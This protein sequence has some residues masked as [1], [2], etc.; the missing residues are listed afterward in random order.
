MKKFLDTLV[1]RESALSP[2]DIEAFKSNDN[3]FGTAFVINMETK[4][5]RLVEACRTLQ[6]VGKTFT[7]F[8]AISGAK[9]LQQG[10]Q[11]DIDVG[12]FFSILRPGE[13]GCVLSHLSLI[14]LAAQHPNQNNFTIIFEDDVVTSATSVEDTLARVAAID[15]REG[16]D[17]VY[18]GK[19]L[20]CC[21]KMTRIEDNIWRGVAPSC[22][23]A[24]AIKNSF[25]RK[26]MN[27]IEECDYGA[28]N[29]EYFNR[30]IDSI[31]GD[32]TINAEANTLVIH[33]AIFMQ[34]VL[35]TSSD[36]RASFL[37]NYLECR[38]TTGDPPAPPQVAPGSSQSG[39]PDWVKMTL[40][41]I[42]GVVLLVL[43][44]KFITRHQKPALYVTIVLLFVYIVILTMYFTNKLWGPPGDGPA[45]GKKI[46][47]ESFVAPN[48]TSPVTSQHFEVDTTHLLTKEYKAFNPNAVVKDGQIVTAFRVS[49]G[50][51]S[52]PLIE[53]FDANLKLIKSK[54]VTIKSD[55]KVLDYKMPL[56]FE[57]MRIF[58]HN[59]EIGLIGVNLDRNDTGIASMV[60][61]RLDE[62]LETQNVTHLTYPPV[63]SKT[64]K[65]W[66]PITL[67]G[68][69]LG[70]VVSVD[71]LLIVTQTSEDGTC[72]K[73]VEA[74][75]NLKQAAVR[76]ST[77]TLRGD[78]IPS[79]YQQVMGITNP[80]NEHFMLVHTK[81][82]EA[83]FK[84]DGKLIQYQ[85][86]IAIVDP[87]KATVR[88]SKPF[89]VEE[90]NRPHIEYVSGF[91]FP[92]QGDLVITYGLKDEEA[93]F[94]PLGAKNMSI[95]F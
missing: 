35:T 33:P 45:A 52:Y 31:L 63:A 8:K 20:E 27:D 54:R 29:C 49:N 93:K 25:A 72:S 51:A 3:K 43:L 74:P 38:D 58:E 1:Q 66:A 79:E 83:D 37:H 22:C 7:R 87:Y 80:Q 90:P 10:K 56:G 5:E 59:G 77:V 4:P 62:N 30:G 50:K 17:L 40:L 18:L 69:R 16:V 65:N 68:N 48:L 42:V 19:C 85:H 81:Y 23:H 11:D 82:V 91:F 64:N 41:V 73:V 44:T 32:Y 39:G 28:P 71:P 60:V 88:L 70:Y 34:D 92:P 24:Y 89:H 14:N 55:R 12:Q 6:K 9:I 2:Q 57:D 36:L 84:K 75:Q 67:S 86:Y 15:D 53:V 76:N 95:L 61:A 94:F 26:V 46:T 47:I 21:S 78:H 13:A